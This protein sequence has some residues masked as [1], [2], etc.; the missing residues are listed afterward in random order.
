MT[1][2]R[3]I[4]IVHWNPRRFRASGP[5]NRLGAVGPR[6]NNFGDLLGPLIINE[7]LSQEGLA[8]PVGHAAQRVLAVGSILGLARPGDA[9]WGTGVNGK[10]IDHEVRFEDVAFT[11]VRGPLTRA[12]ATERGATVPEV[13]GDP[14]LLLGALF[15]REKL[16]GAGEQRKL[17]VVPNFHDFAASPRNQDVLNPRS[18]VTAVL[19]RIANSD[20]V[21]GSSLHGVIVAESL[22]IPARFIRSLHEPKFKY[23]DYMLGTGRSPAEFASSVEEAREMGGQDGPQFDPRHLLEAFPRHLW[24]K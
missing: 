13:Y 3:G 22:G 21:C 10:S 4:E 14:A 8:N 20:F 19:Q 7:I 9:V 6:I 2:N 1:R 5:L 15:G 11:A 24:T 16:S 17:T 23:D 18:S 12:W